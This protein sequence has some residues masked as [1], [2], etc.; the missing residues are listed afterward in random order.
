[1][2]Q[3]NERFTTLRRVMVGGAACPES[4][5]GGFRDD[6]GIDV[7][8]AWGMTETSPLATISTPSARVAEMSQ[9]AQLGYKLK[10][11][12]LLCGLEQKLVDDDRKRLPH[13]GKSPGHL[14]IRGTTICAGYFGGGD[15][16]LD[17]EGYFGTSDVATIDGDGYMQI[18]DRAKDIIKSGGEWISSIEIENIVSGHPKAARAAVLGVAHPQWSERP[19]LLV[20]LTPGASAE[21]QEFADFLDGKIARWWMPDA[22]HIVDEMP[23]GATG[24]IDKKAIRACLADLMTP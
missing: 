2:R 11:G 1:V 21:P 14:M 15:S 19:V 18:T 13:D 16:P 8:H 20:Q 23:L 4:I 7:V 22:I 17:A 12:R 3:S 24:K 9:D 6:F 10:Q 5:V